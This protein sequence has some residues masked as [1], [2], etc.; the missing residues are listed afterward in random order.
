M[1]TDGTVVQF[2]E[3][4]VMSWEKP[5]MTESDELLGYIYKWGDSP[6]ALSDDDF[7]NDLG[8]KDGDIDKEVT[9]YQEGAATFA[10]DDSTDIRYLH[11]KT[12]FYDSSAEGDGAAYSSDVVIGGTTG[13]INIDNVAPTGS[14][15]ITDGEDSD[16]TTTYSTRLNLQLNASEAPVTM[17][18]SETEEQQGTG[19]DYATDVVYDLI[20]E[21]TGEKTIYVWFEDGVGNIPTAPAT[22]SVTLLVPVSI[23]PY[24]PTLDPETTSTQD[25]TVNGNSDSYDWEIIEESPI[26]PGDNVADFS[27]V[28]TD[29]NSVTVNIRNKGTF[30]LRATPAGDGDVLTSGVIRVGTVSKT[31]SMITTAT[32]NINMIG[33]V[34]ENTGYTK[35]S[36]L[37]SAIPN[38]DTVWSWNVVNQG[39]GSYSAGMPD[40]RNFDLE[41]GKAYLVN[42]TQDGQFTLE[43]TAPASLQISL[44]TTATTNLNYIAL[45]NHRSGLSKAL[46]LLGS[47]PNSDT[48][49]KWNVQNQGLDSYST[50]MPDFR[51][52]D[53]LWGDG[54]IVNVTS[55]GTW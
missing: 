27:G 37:L 16:I 25:F 19:T 43:G 38:C 39:V 47:I 50:G 35:A 26:T 40:F 4:L 12:H 32:T 3:D 2:T 6:D 29:T 34:L 21:T 30:K 18:L 10:S 45:P 15:R 51:N 31:F 13:G 22:D 49:W 36:D 46:D 1:P 41:L 20:D 55:D 28:I 11:F 33:F 42:V 5:A 54:F 52:F 7:N 53:I 9:T 8:K 23:S 24:A 14:V 17:Y 48:V 44:S